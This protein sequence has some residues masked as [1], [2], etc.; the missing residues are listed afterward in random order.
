MNRVYTRT[1]DSG[2]TALLYGGRASK[3]A[4]LFDALGDIDEAVAALGVARS[5]CDD[6]RRAEVLFR[7]QRELF[8][9]AAD[10]AA[11]PSHRDRLKPGVS[12]VEP[13]MTDAL[14][15]LIDELTA[16]QPLRPVFLVPGTTPQEAAIDL[17][18][19]IVRRAERHTVQARAAGQVA[20]EDVAKYL[21]RLSDLLFVLARQAAEGA[22]EPVSHD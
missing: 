21:N 6:E 10:L 17:G 18:R 15:R 11:N 13:A 16:E 2:T 7:L 14:E 5:G 20:S 3:A 8:I 1:G 9:V 4:E 12:L 19:T 22:E